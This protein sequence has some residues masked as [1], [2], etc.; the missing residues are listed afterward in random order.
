MYE[1]IKSQQ[2][3]MGV[4]S[5]VVFYLVAISSVANAMVSQHLMSMTSGAYCQEYI[6][7]QFASSGHLQCAIMYGAEKMCV[8][9]SHHEEQ[10]FLHAGF[11]KANSL[12]SAEGSSYSGRCIYE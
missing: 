11:C 7:N 3:K 6:L 5:A 8:A 10:C 12:P 9:F 1:I 4:S 2:T